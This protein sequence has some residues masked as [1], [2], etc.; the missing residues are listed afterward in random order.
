MIEQ[1]LG[2]R[3]FYISELR[4][5]VIGDLHIG[6]EQELKEKGVIVPDQTGEMRER[7]E[8]LVRRYDAKKLI[9]LGDLKHEIL[10][11]SPRIYKFLE[12]LP[13]ELHLAKGNHDGRIEEIFNGRVYPPGGFRL[14][15]YGFFH[16]HSWPDEDVMRARYVF[17]GHLHPEIELED[18]LG[19][20]HR[21][22]CHL[23]GELSE[24]G[25]ERYRSSPKI[26]V[27]AA[28][29]RLVGASIATPIGPLLRNGYIKEFQVYLLNGTYL[30]RYSYERFSAQE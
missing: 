10:G 11:F 8:S 22:P 28:F 13:V 29:N 20:R 18:S 5:I 2:E 7:I 26:F 16:G 24:R 30:G 15:D 19:H 6:Y 14:G 23:V 1:V 4:A 12:N 9:I 25:L 17:M 3:A 27:V 21:Y